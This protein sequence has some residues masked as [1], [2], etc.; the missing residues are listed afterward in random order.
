M[1]CKAEV[2][3]IR[4]IQQ[5]FAKFSNASGLQA[6]CDKSSLYFSG[7]QPT[8]KQEILSLLGYNEGSSTL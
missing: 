5:A 3:L 6:N 4:L 7:V 1:F 8:V 2:R